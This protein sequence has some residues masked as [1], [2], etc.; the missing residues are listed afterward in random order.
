MRTPLRVAMMAFA[1]AAPSLDAQ[2]VR[3]GA[4][5]PEID[6]PA[7]SGRR[8][9]LSTLRGH[10]VV[11]SFWTTWCPSCRTEFPE[12]V[13]L[14]ETHGPELRILGVKGRDQERST[15]NVQAFLA[16]VGAS[17]PVALDER[18]I[19]RRKYRLFGQPTMVFIDSAGVIRRIH[20][21]PISREELDRGVAEILPAPRPSMDQHA[22]GVRQPTM[23]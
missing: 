14:Q 11:V 17:F 13:R 9:R 23:S 5:A 12:L 3:V 15:K 16:E 8:V 21:G 20:A 6:L 18:G 7:L 10:P 19:A 1:L 22:S 2:P 4:S